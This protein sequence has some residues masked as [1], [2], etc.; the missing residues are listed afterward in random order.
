MLAEM[1]SDLR[2]SQHGAKDTIS[3]RDGRLLIK[4]LLALFFFFFGSASPLPKKLEQQPDPLLNSCPLQIS[5][6]N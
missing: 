5:W 1:N 3:M 4:S 6:I 2:P